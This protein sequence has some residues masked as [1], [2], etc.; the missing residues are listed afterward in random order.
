[1]RLCWMYSDVGASLYD[2]LCNV[3]LFVCPAIES[4]LILLLLKVVKIFL[5]V[6]VCST[7]LGL[8]VAFVGM[9]VAPWR[10]GDDGAAVQHG[11]GITLVTKAFHPHAGGRAQQGSA[12]H[13]GLKL[14]EALGQRC[15]DCAT[16]A[17]TNEVLDAPIAFFL[18][19][20]GL[21]GNAVCCMLCAKAKTSHRLIHL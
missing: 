5:F 16:K 21:A 13:P 15:R 9:G 4:S 7:T 6:C 2:R 19:R 14:G 20:Q 18:M 8:L 3:S 12:I 11:Y 10:L 1:M 17:M